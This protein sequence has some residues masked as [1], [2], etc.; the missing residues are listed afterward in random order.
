ML[1]GDEKQNFHYLR[2][3]RDIVAQDSKPLVFWVGAGC[4][5]WKG[6]SGWDKLAEEFHSVYAKQE[7]NYDKAKG[8]ELLAKRELPSLFQELKSSN[9]TLYHRTLASSFQAK[10]NSPVY[11]NFI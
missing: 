5:R 4:S 8:S 7:P 11:D 6:Y 2:R 9:R 3:L 10:K 1:D